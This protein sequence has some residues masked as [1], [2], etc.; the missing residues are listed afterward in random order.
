MSDFEKHFKNALSFVVPWSD[1]TTKDGQSEQNPLNTENYHS[2]TNG[3]TNDNE[4]ATPSGPNSSTYKVSRAFMFLS[5]A[6][7][8]SGVSSLW[9]FVASENTSM[10]MFSKN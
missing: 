4:R 2:Q 9:F 7:R 10:Y 1:T 6:E 5:K 8:F 3:Y